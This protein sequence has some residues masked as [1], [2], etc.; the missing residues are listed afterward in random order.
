M[1]G[2]AHKR[3]IPN[4]LRAFADRRYPLATGGSMLFYGWL[5]VGLGLAVGAI[6]ISVWE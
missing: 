6:A 1:F 2:K 4:H 5:F 3:P